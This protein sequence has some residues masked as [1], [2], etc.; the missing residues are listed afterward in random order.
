[1]V[2]SGVLTLSLYHK[3]FYISCTLW[4]KYYWF[5]IKFVLMNHFQ[6]LVKLLST[7]D[8]SVLLGALLALTT[9]AE[10]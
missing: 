3:I 1:M 7:T 10:R 4:K 5:L 2:A 6:T 9:L 8:S